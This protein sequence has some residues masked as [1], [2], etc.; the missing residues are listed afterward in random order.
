MH[1]FAIVVVVLRHFNTYWSATSGCDRKNHKAR[2]AYGHAQDY[3][4]L[5]ILTFGDL[6]MR[7]KCCCHS[8]HSEITKIAIFL[9]GYWHRFLTYLLSILER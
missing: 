7:E 1:R 3:V 2:A 9:K 5:K 6:N 8:S 4:A